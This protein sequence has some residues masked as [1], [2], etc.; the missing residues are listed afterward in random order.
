MDKSSDVG[1]IKTSSGKTHV[2]VHALTYKPAI[3]NTQA[4]ITATSIITAPE[5]KRKICTLQL[6]PSRFSSVDHPRN[7]A[8]HRPTGLAVD[9][10]WLGCLS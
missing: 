5:G 3:L 10:R 6:V 8:K 7:A 1:R 4:M 9:I 2:E